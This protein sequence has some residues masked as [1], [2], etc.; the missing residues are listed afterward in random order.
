MPA[1]E[2]EGRK[3]IPYQL[4]V[5]SAEAGELQKAI[6]LGHDLANIDFGFRDIGKLLDDWHERLQ[7]A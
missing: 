7:E 4:A 5:G 2:E 6:D 3:E 1:G